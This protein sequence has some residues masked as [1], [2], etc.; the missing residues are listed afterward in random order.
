MSNKFDAWAQSKEDAAARATLEPFT[1]LVDHSA[2]LPL[3]RISHDFTDRLLD[4]PFYQSLLPDARPAVNL[5]FVQSREGNTDADNPSLLGGGATDKHIIY[6]GLS[7]VGADAVLSGS[8]TLGRSHM[9]F[10]VWH[11]ELVRLRESLG[12]PRHPVQIV[13]TVKGDLPIEDGLLYNVP[14]IPVVIL[15]AHG[16]PL[17]E[18][19]RSRSWIS[20]VDF[21]G[22]SLRSGIERLR[23]EHGL[24]RIS[25]IGGRHA[26]TALLDA[27]V[28][29]D[30]YLTTSPSTAG[31]PNTPFYMG[32]RPPSRHL[33]VRKQSPTGVVFEHLL[34]ERAAATALTSE[35]T[36]AT[37]GTS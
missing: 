29:D 2:P 17:A 23:S 26:A 20:V 8:K 36:E 25:A 28:I 16:E 13:M 11:P 5:V 32:D 7:R 9:I 4:G 3:D 1:T 14:D 35:A 6:E 31:Q 18:R 10:S 24:E 30:L 12:K 34:L 22:T 33:V 19:V 27:G 15:T 21:G 37:K